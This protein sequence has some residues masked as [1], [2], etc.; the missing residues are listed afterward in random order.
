MKSDI[1][2]PSS[3]EARR[4]HNIE[5]AATASL[6]TQ[7]L[8]RLMAQATDPALR[9]GPDSVGFIMVGHSGSDTWLDY[10]WHVWWDLSGF[11]RDD[12]TMPNNGTVINIVRPDGALMYF[13]MEKILYTRQGHGIAEPRQR[14]VEAEGFQLPSIEERLVEFPLIR[15]RLPASDWKLESLH[16]ETYLGRPASRLRAT[17]RAGSIRKNDSRLSG[18]WWGVD[19]YECVIDNEQQIVMSVTGIVD[20]VSVA[21]ISVEHMIVDA[22]LAAGTFEFSPPRG[23][24]IVRGREK[25]NLGELQ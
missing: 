22:T 15:P 12:F 11:W 10:K 2:W 24:R 16:P 18:F 5:V 14:S 23:T 1:S 20:R 7:A 13:S 25:T 21:T 3:G 6:D 19:E 8:A 9:E 17:R 4:L